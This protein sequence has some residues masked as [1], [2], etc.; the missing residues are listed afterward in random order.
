MRSMAF[1]LFSSFASRSASS[2][3]KPTSLT[4]E[5]SRFRAFTQ[6]LC[7]SVIELYLSG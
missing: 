6:V 4:A 1:G 2:F 3:G 7:A 5:A